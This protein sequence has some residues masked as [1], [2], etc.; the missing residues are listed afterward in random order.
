MQ[1]KIKYLTFTILLLSIICSCKNRSASSKSVSDQVCDSIDFKMVEAPAM[2]SGHDEVMAYLVEHFWDNLNEKC[3]AEK[4]EQAFADWVW[5]SGQ[6]DMALSCKSILKAYSKSPDRILYLAEKY[7][8]NPQSPYRNEDIYGSLCEEAGGELAA[9]ARL[10]ALNAVGTR[11]AD[12]VIEDAKGKRFTLHDV[13]ADYTLLFFSNPYCNA[14]KDIINILKADELVSGA[15]EKGTL[16]VV[17][18]YVDE[19][20]EQWRAYLGAYPE[21]WRTGFD[22]TFTLRDNEKYNIRAIPSL[23][24]LS[25]DK[26]V[27]LKDAPIE[28]VIDR[29]QKIL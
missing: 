5:L 17:N 21:S 4:L 8:Y 2:M 13:K 28:K 3:Y 10:C 6:V 14:C 27:L 9:T 23:Y 15:I 29:L 22:P 16:A 12:F 18:M 24:L 7:L 11:A 1:M 26:T 25:E 19:D 20:L